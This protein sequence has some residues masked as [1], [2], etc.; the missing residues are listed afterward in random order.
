[1]QEKRSFLSGLS[2]FFRKRLVTLKRK[3]HQVA[4]VVLAVAFVYFTLNL[5]NFS[6]TTARVNR[7]GMGLAQ[8]VMV[9]FSTLSMVCFMNAF[10]HR[11]KVRVPMLVLMFLMV[12]VVIA[13]GYI[14]ETRID[15]YI[16]DG[17][18][19]SKY[20]SILSAKH[21]LHVHRIILFVSAAITALLPVYTPLLRKINT[22]VEV[23]G[24][25]EMNAID[26]SGE[27]A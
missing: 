8:F 23:A 13:A 16:A 14:Y 4:L 20:P 3:P 6:N 9:L 17:M 27:D 21:V 19:V 24:N 10:P 18:D 22:N 26:I 25:G 7:A 1:M 2:E 11:K 15:A 5:T 12:G